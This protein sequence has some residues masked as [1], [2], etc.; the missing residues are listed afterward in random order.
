M[1]TKHD[2]E[3]LAGDIRNPVDSIRYL[4]AASR[5][6]LVLS[7][8]MRED[9]SDFGARLRSFEA[10]CKKLIAFGEKHPY[11]IKILAMVLLESAKDVEFG[12]PVNS[13][14]KKRLEDVLLKNVNGLSPRTFNALVMR[15]DIQTLNELADH[16]EADLLKIEGFGARSLRD[17][18]RVLKKR[19]MALKTAT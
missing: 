7:L 11:E 2:P 6:M 8:K 10:N 17:V 1:A 13:E 12:V 9:I 18:K 15:T 19:G 16:T 3:Q 5:D 4:Q 14:E